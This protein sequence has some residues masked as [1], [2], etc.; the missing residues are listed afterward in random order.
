MNSLT[1]E[2]KNILDSVEQGKWQSVD[3]LSEEINRYQDY[4]NHHI[5]RQTIEVTL[6]VEDAQKIQG[7]ANQLGTSIVD[8]SQEILHRY[9][10]GEFQ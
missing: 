9:L 6:S 1:P 7:L 8:L 4:A 3:H 10:Q 2:E 5:N